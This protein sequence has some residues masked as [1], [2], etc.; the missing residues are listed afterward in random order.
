MKER[1]DVK[2]YVYPGEKILFQLRIGR[3]PTFIIWVSPKLVVHAEDRYFLELPAENVRIVRGRKDLILLPGDRN[4]FNVY[5]HCAVDRW[6]GWH[7]SSISIDTC[8]CEAF[9][10]EPDTG[11]RAA[12]VLTDSPFVEYRWKRA[13]GQA[14]DGNLRVEEGFGIVQVDGVVVEI[15]GEKEDAFASLGQ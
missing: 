10:Y 12:L 3:K 5:T 7:E 2:K 6:L 14:A 11:H 8:P 15:E 1:L 4:L 9:A 13:K